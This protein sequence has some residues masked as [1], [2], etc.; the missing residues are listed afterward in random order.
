MNLHFLS[1]LAAEFEDLLKYGKEKLQQHLRTSFTSIA[2]HMNSPIEDLFG[3]LLD[4]LNGIEVDIYSIVSRFFDALFPHIYKTHINPSVSRLDARYRDCLS[5]QASMIMPFGYAPEELA[6]VLERSLTVARMFLRAVNL[7]VEVMNSTENMDLTPKCTRALMKMRYCGQC[8]SL[9]GV[10]ACQGFCFN[11]VK[12]CLA[13]F[14]DLDLYWKDYVSAVVDLVRV[15]MTAE[16]DLQA[17]MYTLDQRVRA[18]INRAIEDKA[19]IVQ[20]VSSLFH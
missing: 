18:A 11:V 13:N 15:S 8:Q 2:I 6:E 16:F 12:G 4:Y 1:L 5:N 14:M 20:A 9:I 3:S 7:G 17:A 10:P 19:P